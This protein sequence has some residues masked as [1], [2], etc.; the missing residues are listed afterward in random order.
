M[1]AKFIAVVAVAC[2]A[3]VVAGTALAEPT[4]DTTKPT[5]T[6]S[7]LPAANGAGWNNGPVT[8]TFTC[9]D[10]V[11]GSGIATDTVAGA[12]LTGGGVNQSV[13]NTGTCVDLA[14]NIA[15]PATV[16]GI[17]IDVTYPTVSFTGIGLYTLADT[18]TVAC[19]PSDALS[20]VASSTCTAPPPTPAWT[21]GVGTYQVS[22]LRYRLGWKRAPRSVDVRDRGGQL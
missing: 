18:V 21:L 9:T 1:K 10:E 8:V 7:S 19:V 5:I 3:L 6:G 2:T 4:L 16:S 15:D 13:T 20:G 14:G 22:R 12:T 17:N 11:G